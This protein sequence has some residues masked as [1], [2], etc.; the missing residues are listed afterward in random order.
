[1]LGGVQRAEQQLPRKAVERRGVELEPQRLR[2]KAA[3]RQVERD[4]VD[5]LVV[6]EPPALVG[7]DG[8][9]DEHAAEGQRHAE[10]LAPVEQALDQVSVSRFGCVYQSP[11]N[12]STSARRASMSSSST[13]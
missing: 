2:R 9:G 3:G 8:L 11:S 13:W 6:A 10:R 7:E 4:E 12:G 5:L 1:V